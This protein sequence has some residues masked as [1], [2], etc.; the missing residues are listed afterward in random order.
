[1]KL[2]VLL[3]LFCGLP[4]VLSAQSSLPEA[5]HQVAKSHVTTKKQR[6]PE[7]AL[8]CPV[9]ES[10]LG[11]AD[12]AE[13]NMRSYLLDAV[14]GGLGKCDPEKVRDALVNSFISTLAI[15]ETQEEVEQ[16]D[17]TFLWNRE[18]PDEATQESRFNLQMKE[19]LQ[20]SALRHLLTIDET[21]VDSLLPQAEPDVRA[22]LM[23]QMIDQATTA[24]KFDRALELLSRAPSKEW[25]PSRFPFREATQLM[26]ELP[27][28]REQDMQ[29]IFRVA[30]TAD[31]ERP[32]FTTGGDDLA[33]MIVRFWRHLPPEIV[34]EA[35][36]QVL[37]QANFFKEG[38]TLNSGSGKMAFSSEHDYRVFELL[39]VL[40]E[41]DPDE[42]DKMLQSSQQAQLH[43]KQFPNGIQS[44]DPSLGDSGPKAG[45]RPHQTWISTPDM[46]R[47]MSNP[48]NQDLNA[49][50]PRVQEI[51][52][53][54]E[55][56]PSQAMAAAATLPET[57]GSP[58]WPFVFPRVQAY[59]GIARTL[60]KKNPSVAGQAL[61]QMSEFLKAMAPH[62]QTTGQWLEAIAIA[63]EMNDA[64]LALKLFR[65]GMRQ[66]DTLRSQDNDPDDPNTAIKAFWPSVCAYSGLVLNIA[67]ISP[68]TALQRIQKIK[69]P[70]ILLLL[71]VKLANKELSGDNFHS[72]ASCMV[73]KRSS[74]FE[75]F[76]GSA[77]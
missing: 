35:I 48:I 8:W 73:H 40:K 31:R 28:D 3:L 65:L 32:S 33:D 45:E 4:S 42:A 21:K 23:Q 53:T 72:P 5:N 47:A 30:M 63:R 38:L 25:F 29:E 43:L 15:P 50:Q 22:G 55:E 44:L 1:M 17:W 57:I 10:A 74:H 16:R 36:H 61:G 7:E 34:L 76:S 52:R 9:L 51:V 13:P 66:A 18:Q 62:S 46:D 19:A 24:K 56:N 58:D 37:D 49:Y 39:P 27:P 75:M 20:Q 26:L 14:A 60:M 70:E 71:E 54:A 2:L 6:S 77:N 41:L 64:G 69:D 68:Q 67:Q 12:N 11:G 59:L